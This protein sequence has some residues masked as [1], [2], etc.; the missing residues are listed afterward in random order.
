M[1]RRLAVLFCDGAP[2]SFV[3][4]MLGRGLLPNIARLVKGGACVPLATSCPAESPVA[5]AEALTGTNP[6][7]HGIFDFLHRDPATYLPRIALYDVTDAG[8]SPTL[9][10]PTISEPLSRAGVRHAFIRLPGTF[11]APETATFAA[12]GLGIPDA[13]GS[14]G[15]G[16]I[17]RDGAKESDDLF[18]TRTH[19]LRRVGEAYVLDV[20]LARDPIALFRDGD[21]FR[22]GEV[23]FPGNRFGPWIEVGLENGRRG[24]LAVCP[25]GTCDVPVFVVTPVWEHPEDTRLPAFRPADFGAKLCARHGTQPVSGWPEPNLLL[26]EDNIPFPAFLELCERTSAFV[27][28]TIFDALAD[29]SL[30]L[31]FADLELFDRLAHAGFGDNAP[32]E[33]RAALAGALVRFDGVVGSIVREHPELTLWLA[34]DHGFAPWT[35]RVNINRIL[36]DWGYLVVEG[37]DAD[38]SLSSLSPGG[39]LWSGVDWGRSRAYALGLSKVYLNLEGREAAGIV[40]PGRPAEILRA[41]IADRLLDLRDPETGA[42]VLRRVFDARRIYW[43]TAMAASGDLVLGFES[44][45]RVDWAG[46]LGGT[47]TPAFAPN[48]SGW[49]ADHCGVDPELIPGFFASAN[50]PEAASVRLRDIAPSILRHFGLAIPEIMDGAPVIR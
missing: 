6:G 11:P 37:G 21:S 23:R 3:S 12:S 22:A 19:P 24:V 13:E 31:V 8:F 48:D 9:R 41:E 29:S 36:R 32:E 35:R 28:S 17:F 44:G 4:E 27:E 50:T 18:G 39:V 15:R 10:V 20:P 30:D 42:R 33:A 43:G 26:A 5:F 14:W 46:S 1:K 16:T 45:Y 2:F 47:G 25:T 40:P 7:K 49:R 34:S 38:P